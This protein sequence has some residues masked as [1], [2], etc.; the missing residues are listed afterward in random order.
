MN[1]NDFEDF[2]EF[3]KKQIGLLRQKEIEHFRIYKK[4]YNEWKTCPLEYLKH[5]LDYQINKFNEL[6]GK[7]L[8][9]AKSNQQSRPIQLII[10]DIKDALLDI[11][12]YS[13]FLYTRIRRED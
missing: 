13:Y 10:I 6:F 5:R 8:P 4:E 12:N 1:L 7:E 2:I 9:H 11:A 3:T